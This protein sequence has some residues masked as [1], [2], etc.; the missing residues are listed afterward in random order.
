VAV[1][2]ATDDVPWTRFDSIHGEVTR[3]GTSWA[4]ALDFVNREGI[5]K[6]VLKSGRCAELAEAAAV[7]IALAYRSGARSSADDWNDAEPASLDETA[8]AAS[9]EAKTALAAAEKHAARQPSGERG[10]LPITVALGAEALL[11]PTTLGQPALGAGVGLEAR[12]GAFSAK[13]YGVGFP[14]IETRV[15]PGQ[16]IAL[17]LL[18]GGLRGCHRW[19]RGLA[20]CAD[21]ELGELTSKGV[22]L[23]QASSGR[24]AWVAPGLSVELESTPFDA[25]GITTRVSAYRPLVRGQFRVDD[26]AVI[27]RIPALSFRAT[28]GIDVPLF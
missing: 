22:G 24:D 3:D 9:H 17:G 15:A 21:F 11:D 28:L 14:S 25:F 18:T 7:A 27:H 5:R 10:A 16:A 26:G 23:A 6:R 13:L 19:V 2:A 1:L 8:G 20:T 12:L 4:L